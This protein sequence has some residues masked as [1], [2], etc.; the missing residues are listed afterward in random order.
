MYNDESVLQKRKNFIDNIRIQKE[1][2]IC[3][4]ILVSLLKVHGS[5]AEK[6]PFVVIDG[7]EDSV[8]VHGDGVG[9][10]DGDGGEWK[11]LEA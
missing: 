11:T 6:V 5:G 2:Y 4:S 10:G 1:V 7:D 8:K 3:S 9:A